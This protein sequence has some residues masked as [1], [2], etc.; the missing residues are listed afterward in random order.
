[1]NEITETDQRNREWELYKAREKEKPP[2]DLDE[3]ALLRWLLQR[4]KDVRAMRQAWDNKW[5]PGRH[6]QAIADWD[7]AVKKLEKKIQEKCGGCP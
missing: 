2:P 1:M 3:C 5:H 7:R 4:A 6:R